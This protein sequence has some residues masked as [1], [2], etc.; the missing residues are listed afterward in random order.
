MSRLLSA[1]LALL[2]AAVA[3][4]Q[5]PSIEI[6]AEIRPAG[7]YV[8]VSPKTDAVAVAYVGLDGLDG[9]P[10]DLLKDGR[11][12]LLDTRGLARGRYRFAAVA[13]GKTG[14]QARADF[15]VVIGDAPP[16]PPGPN[17]PTP[18]P[19]VPP[20]PVPVTGLRVLIVEESADRPKLPASQ[21]SVLFSKSVRDWLDAHCVDGEGG[22]KDWGIFDKDADLSRYSRHLREM[23]ARPRTSLPWVVIK[24]DGGIVHE[25]PLPVDVPAALNLL[26][27]YAPAKRKA[28]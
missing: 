5:P 12:F 7:Q 19:P 17:P 15:V 8:R 6:P 14:E 10:S 13:A 25:G 22:V 11:L 3:L 21:Q 24:G 28:G 26:G 1:P 18:D 16:N 20:V 2:L 27:K 23:L 9:V 4:A